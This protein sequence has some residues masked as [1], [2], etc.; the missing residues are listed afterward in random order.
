MHYPNTYRL[1]VGDS[2]HFLI[3]MPSDSLIQVLL[4]NLLSI[5]PLEALGLRI[6]IKDTCMGLRLF[7]LVNFSIKEI[8]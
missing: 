4:R 2:G 7:I 8:R 1:D 6:F 3:V 5:H